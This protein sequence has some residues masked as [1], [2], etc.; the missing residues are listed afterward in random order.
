MRLDQLTFSRFIAAIAVVIYHFGLEVYPFNLK[1]LYPFFK[2]GNIAVSYFFLLSGFIMIIAYHQYKKVAFLAY[3][4]NRFARIYPVYF[5]AL[6]ILLL[7]KLRYHNDGEFG[8]FFL[9]LVMIQ[10]WF[11]GKA[12]SFNFPAWSLGVEFFFYALFPLL[13]NR[14]YAQFS[15]KK[16]CFMVIPFFIMSQLL[17]HWGMY[18]NW[19]HGYPSKSHELLFYFPPM[20]LSEFLIG[21]LAGL[22]FVKRWSTAKKNY[23]FLILSFVC[24]LP[25]ILYY[26]IYFEFHNGLLALVFIPLIVCISMNEGILS[27][28]SA[29]KPLIFLGEISYGIY[30]LQSP[31]FAWTKAILKDYN[32]NNETTKFYISLLILVVIAALSYQFIEAP[33]RKIIKKISI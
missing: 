24:L 26:N 23:D 18:S 9:N 19:Y 13:F 6:L 30:I 4:K 2:Q 20:H 31:I 14:Y 27:K 21:N 12:L 17:F 25:A 15:L 16:L 22:F 1:E 7:F 5:L 3:I 10:S 8:D 29:Y 33:L 28:I 11:P 32:I